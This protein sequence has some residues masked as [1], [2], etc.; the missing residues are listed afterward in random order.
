MRIFSSLIIVGLF[1][2]AIWLSWLGLG[3]MMLSN[4]SK[5]WPSVTGTI[6]SAGFETRG[7]GQTYGRTAF[8]QYR[9]TVDNKQ[10]FGDLIAFGP[11][12]NFNVDGTVELARNR[13]IKELATRIGGSDV[14]VYYDPEDPKIAVLLPGGTWH[15][16]LYLF[17]STLMLAFAFMLFLIT[18]GRTNIPIYRR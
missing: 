18:T 3:Q 16:I 14:T 10:Y 5:S 1:T 9:Y 4:E 6:V 2:G 11:T 13:A 15:F 7:T 12:P 17:G 8:V